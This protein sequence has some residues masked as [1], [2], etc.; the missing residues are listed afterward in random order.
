[1]SWQCRKEVFGMKLDYEAFAE[2]STSFY[3]KLLIDYG[4]DKISYDEAKQL[5][6]A[7]D[8][9]LPWYDDEALKNF[10]A[11]LEECKFNKLS[12]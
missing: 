2:T 6:I 1:M 4:F 5:A 7:Y 11:L 9:C 10:F 3:D 12:R 8:E